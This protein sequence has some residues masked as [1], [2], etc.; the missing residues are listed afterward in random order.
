M[1]SARRVNMTSGI[2][3]KGRPKLSTTWLRTSVRVGSRP[4]PITISAGSIV[5]KRRSQTGICRCRKP[6]MM[7]CP[8]I[9]PTVEDESPEA[10]SESAKTQDDAL[11]SSGSSVRCAS[12]IVPISVSP[13]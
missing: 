5:T 13:C 7:T 9:V 10:S 11:P 8:A 6:C 1:M 2:M 3:A 12:S 4:I